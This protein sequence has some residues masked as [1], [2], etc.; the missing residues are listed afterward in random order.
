MLARGIMMPKLGIATMIALARKRGGRCISTL[1]VSSTVPLLWECAN[2]HR[3]NAVPASIRKGTRC[4]DCAGVRR[5]TLEQM[6]VTAKSRGGWCL[7][8]R[9]RNN[10][11]KLKWRCSK[12]HEW[13][14]TPLHVRKGH[15]CPFCAR[16]ASVTLAILQQIAARRGG[17]CL[18]ITYVNSSCPLLWNCA[19]GHEWLARASSIQA[20]NWCP[21]CAHNQSLGLE[22]M[23]EIARER[24]GM[25]LSTSYKNASTPLLWTCK[26]GHRWKA[27]AANVKSGS[28]RKGSWCR[29]CYNWRRRF[30]EKL[31][32]EAMRGLATTRGGT[33]LSAEYFG[34]KTKLTWKCEFGHR[35]EAAPCYVVQ[36][37]WCP[38]CAR[39]E[40]LR[41]TLFQELAVNKGGMCLSGEYVNEHTVL[42]FR[43]AEGHEWKALPEKIKRGSWCPKCARAA[44]RSEWILQRATQQNEATGQVELSWGVQK[45]LPRPSPQLV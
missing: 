24:G 13:S 4:P 44:R 15:W 40:R 31:S 8:K 17:R 25:C 41:L 16:V 42:E 20:G 21:V 45:S 3:W 23:R 30:H 39:N 26:F 14:A 32:I 1:Y 18:S 34:S 28:R 2:G 12:G 10:A 37:T 43:C 36:G 29:E 19:A 33:C 27:A 5:L 11:E 35:W 38:T 6:R 7:S 9:Y 22:E